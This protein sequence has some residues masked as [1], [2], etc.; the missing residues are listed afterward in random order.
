M[1]VTAQTPYNTSIAAAGATVFPYGFKILAAG[2]LRVLVDGV[3][4]TLGVDFTISGVGQD[5]GGN[6]TFVTPLTG[7]QRVLRKSAMAYERTTD[8]QNLGDLHSAT[9][10]NDQDSPVLMIR[11]LAAALGLS[12]QVPEMYQ[13]IFSPVLPAPSPLAPLVFSSDGSRLEAGSVLGTGD[14]LLRGNLADPDGSGAALVTIKAAGIGAVPRTVQS[15]FREV[16]SV[17][18]FGAKG[19]GVTDDTDALAAALSANSSVFMPAGTYVF[20]HDMT[21]PSNRRLLGAGSGATIIKQKDSVLPTFG[22]FSV[23]SC[24]NILIEGMTFQGNGVDPATPGDAAPAMFFLNCT[25]ARV[26]NCQFTGFRGLGVAFQGGADGEVTQCEFNDH[27]QDLTAWRGLSPKAVAAVWMGYSNQ[28]TVI[29]GNRFIN[30]RWSAIFALG[31]RSIISGNYLEHIGESGI[32]SEYSATSPTGY[33]TITGNTILDCYRIDITACGIENISSWSVISN[34]LI[35]G[36]DADGIALSTCANVTVSGN[37]ISNC[38]R[39]ASIISSGIGLSNK[40]AI[41]PVIPIYGHRLAIIGNICFDDQS[42]ATQDYGIRVSSAGSGAAFDYCSIVGNICYRNTVADIYIDS[43]MMDDPTNVIKAN[44]PWDESLSFAGPLQ[45][46]VAGE[47][48]ISAINVPGS[49]LRRNRI[50]KLKAWGTVSGTEGTKSVYFKYDTSQNLF[51][52]VTFAAGETG[53]W[54][55]EADIS[56]VAPNNQQVSVKTIKGSSTMACGQSSIS[57]NSL[58]NQNAAVLSNC[59]SASDRVVLQGFIVERN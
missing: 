8:Y 37:M 46:T 45:N 17:M 30:C 56:N 27:G 33:N 19:D 59:A 28:R 38:G 18:D 23:N 5:G 52:A 1:T 55:I 43:G 14:L 7:G 25:G 41:Q 58:L 6:I 10:N 11:Q 36:C 40:A 29:R 50:L 34:N 31:Q 53:M 35:S 57:A 51:G 16:V 20:S 49:S 39:D 9:L 32:Y 54:F 12:I 22:I 15:K 47:Q 3:V 21:I 42:T 4:K 24:N 13:G 26:R 48:V 2:D 44:S